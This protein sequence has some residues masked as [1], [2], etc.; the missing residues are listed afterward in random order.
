[1]A[2]ATFDFQAYPRTLVNEAAERFGQHV[3]RQVFRHAQ[4]QR[5]L[6]LHR[7]EGLARFFVQAQQAPGKTQQAFAVLGRP[8]LSLTA[9]QQAHPQVLLQPDDLLADG[10]LGQVQALRRTGEVAGFDHADKTAQQHG[11]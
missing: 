5:P 9:V 4:A 3:A 8:D 1:M 7:A 2:Q 11:I 10:R 6:R